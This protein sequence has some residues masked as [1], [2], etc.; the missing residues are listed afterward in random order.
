[1]SNT[2]P[3]LP[4][5][6]DLADD[7]SGG[8]SI[9]ATRDQRLKAAIV[10]GVISAI[11]VLPMMYF[12]GVFNYSARGEKPPFLLS[13][14]MVAAGFALFVALHGY[15]L[16]RDGQTLGKKAV[17]IR[18]VDLNGDI[19]KFSKVLLGRYLSISAAGLIPFVGHFVTLIDALFIFRSDRRC[20][21]DM[22]AGTKVVK[23]KKR[24]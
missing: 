4:P 17:G 22:I 18:I 2:N 15:F 19:P 24:N 21:H 9:D 3:Y 12:A 13:L 5:A 23:V 10:D 6:A 16:K 20:I 8:Q 7:S 14:A 1:M 11:L